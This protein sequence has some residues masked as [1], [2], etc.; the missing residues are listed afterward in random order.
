MDR[1]YFLTNSIESA[2][3]IEK[4]L[5]FRGVNLNHIH[6]ISHHDAEEKIHNVHSGSYFMRRDIVHSGERGLIIG[7]IV[8]LI[9][10]SLL[11]AIAPFAVG[12]ELTLIASTTILSSLFG[13]WVGC[14]IG[15]STENYKIA[16]FHDQL[17]AGQYLMVVDVKSS[18]KE[19]VETLMKQ[20]H[21]ESSFAGEASTT[22][23]PFKSKD[24]IRRAA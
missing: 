18:E 1:M 15:L 13:V 24:T 2:D 14:M 23:N 3:A 22:T 20:K 11:A 10:G 5:V 4:D 12:L 16:Q 8:G 21:P 17:E 9:A 7:L 6:I 19:G